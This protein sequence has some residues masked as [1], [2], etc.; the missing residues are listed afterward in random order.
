MIQVEATD[1]D[2]PNNYN[3]DIRYSILNQEPKMP[4]DDLF[5]IN[6]VTGVIRL[7]AGG[8]DREVRTPSCSF[9]SV[10]TRG[11]AQQNLRGLLLL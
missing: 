2:E 1:L 6:P 10:R 5:A 4:S 9:K 7:I 11:A 8:L 3:S